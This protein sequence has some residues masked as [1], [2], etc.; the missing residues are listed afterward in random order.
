MLYNYHTH[1]TRCN[2]AEG[3]DREYVESA[4]KAGIKTLGFSDHAP[5]LFKNIDYYSTYRMQVD[6]IQDY[7]NSVRE[8]KKEYAKDIDI[9]LGFELEYYPKFHRDQMAYLNSVNPDYIIMGQHFVGNEYSNKCHVYS[10]EKKLDMIEGYVSQVLEGLETGDF[11]YLAHP[12]IVNINYSDKEKVLF[13]YET[14]IKGVKKLNIPL[15]INLLGVREKRHYPNG[16]FWE[17]VGKIGATVTIGVDAHGPMAFSNSLAEQ[18]ALELIK[19]YNLNYIKE[20]FII[21]K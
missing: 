8:L 18:K 12:D 17:L 1:T 9:L 3:Q 16:E 10:N 14:L 19:K 13:Q 7:A 15:E 6:E 4:I 20:P 5:Y 2:H 11:C 21:K